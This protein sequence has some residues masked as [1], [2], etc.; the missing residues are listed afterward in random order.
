M[1]E[2]Q[3]EEFETL[4]NNLKKKLED[5]KNKIKNELRNEEMTNMKKSLESLVNF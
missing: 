3:S 5:I 2:K 1:E 4:K